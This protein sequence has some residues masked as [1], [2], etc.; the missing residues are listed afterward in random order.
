MQLT[1][2]FFIPKTNLEQVIK[3]KGNLYQAYLYKLDNNFAL[4]IFVGKAERPRV[5]KCFLKENER[6]DYASR[7]LKSLDSNLSEW[8]AIK[9]QRQIDRFQGVKLGIANLK[10]GDLF[11]FT[12][13][14]TMTLNSFYQIVQ[15]SGRNLMVIPISSNKTSGDGWSGKECAKSVKNISGYK[16]IPARI[17]G[18]KSITI[19]GEGKAR[20]TTE[21]E[22]HYYNHLD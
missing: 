14:Y 17:T 11:C 10:V 15:K 7:Y 9:K 18:E 12:V 3:G 13:S 6:L 4:K 8:E 5:F 16:T 20:L 22:T 2:N 1:Q 21:S 19:E